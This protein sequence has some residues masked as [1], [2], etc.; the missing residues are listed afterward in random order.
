MQGVPLGSR[1]CSV[2]AA[3]K[4]LERLQRAA[5][6]ISPNQALVQE[7]ARHAFLQNSTTSV[8][9]KIKGADAKVTEWGFTDT[10]CV[11]KSGSQSSALSSASSVSHGSHGSLLEQEESRHQNHLEFL[12]SLVLYK[13]NLYVMIHGIVR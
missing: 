13:H 8:S 9:E 12:G 10:R 3:Q 4:D 5:T 6:D 2:D 1:D 11:V 7:D